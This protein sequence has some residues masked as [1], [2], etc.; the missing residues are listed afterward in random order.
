M[1]EERIYFGIE[2]DQ[3]GK[4]SWKKQSRIDIDN[5]LIE[6]SSRDDYYGT[7][8]FM[9]NNKSKNIIIGLLPLSSLGNKEEYPWG[10]YKHFTGRRRIS[11]REREAVEID[12]DSWVPYAR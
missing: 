2:A 12:S 7:T 11:P 4:F 3:S 9:A 6:A 5:I 8:L 1:G 10:T